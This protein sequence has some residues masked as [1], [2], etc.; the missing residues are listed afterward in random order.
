MTPFV[1][2]FCYELW[3]FCFLLSIV[4]DV[5]CNK[6]KAVRFLVLL[7]ALTVDSIF[8]IYNI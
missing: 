7:P 6:V 8:V 2:R 3:A 1:T 4:D 5:L